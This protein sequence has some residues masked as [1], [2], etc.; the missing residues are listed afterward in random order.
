MHGAHAQSPNLV[1]PAPSDKKRSDS[2][3]IPKSGPPFGQDSERQP[4]RANA[5]GVRVAA[6]EHDPVIPDHEARV[7]DRDV[8]ARLKVDPVVV[9]PLR[10]GV[11]APLVLRHVIVDLLL[12]A[13][14]LGMLRRCF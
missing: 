5:V 3:P 1:Y 6:P 4:W 2:H 14:V 10:V 11:V 7:P 13:P 12:R 8:V 9:A